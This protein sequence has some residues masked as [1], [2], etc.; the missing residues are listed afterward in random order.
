M[1]IKTN[2]NGQVDF[3]L[4]N[5]DYKVKG[6]MLV[7]EALNLVHSGEVKRKGNTF[8]VNDKFV[9]EVEDEDTANV[10][11]AEEP[12]VEAPVEVQ[13][14]VQEETPEETPEEP[15][16]EDRPLSS[17]SKKKAKRKNG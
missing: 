11:M 7:S 10:P 9:F 16:E 6:V 8:I 2:A 12:K 5:G 14:E 17:V 3:T 15:I 1:K 4:L 13:E